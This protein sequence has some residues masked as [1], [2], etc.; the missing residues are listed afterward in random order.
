SKDNNSPGIDAGSAIVSSV[1]SQDI[2]GNIRP[3]GAGFDIGAFEYSSECESSGITSIAV[4]ANHVSCNGGS[5][6]SFSFVGSGGVSPY[7]YSIDGVNFQSSDIFS[8]LS[9]GNYVLTIKDATNCFITVN[10]TVTEPDTFSADFSSTSPSACGSSDGSIEVIPTGGT[11]PYEYNIDDGSYQAGNTFFSLAANSYTIG[12]RDANNCEISIL[13]IIND[14]D[15]FAVTLSTDNVTCNGANDGIISFTASGGTG[16]VEASID[17]TNFQTTAFVNLSFGDYTVIFKDENDC[18]TS[19]D[20]NITEPSALVLTASATDVSCN[21]IED[22]VI[23]VSASGG[24]LGYEY[25]IDGIN[26]SASTTF[27]NLSA[28]DYTVVLRDANGCEVNEQLIIEPMLAATLAKTDITCNGENDGIISFTASGGTGTVEASIDG[29]NFQTTAFVNLASGDYTI[30]LRDENGCE[31]NE[32][33]SI[34]EPPMLAATLAKTD[35]T[36]NGENDGIISFTASGGTGTV[37]ASIDGTNFQ[38]TNFT[39]LTSSNYT[40]TFKDENNC[41]IAVNEAISE[42]DALSLDASFDGSN[43]NLS[44][45]GGIA[46]YNYSADGS[47]FQSESTFT[48]PSG[49]YTFIV[50]DDNACEANTTHTIIITDLET[51][52]GIKQVIAYPNPVTSEIYL[53][54]PK[55]AKEVRIIDQSGRAVFSDNVDE[56]ETRLNISHLE[57]GVYTLLIINNN[58]DV[59]RFKFVKQ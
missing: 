41:I 32:Q 52:L 15:I 39:G 58:G 19:I 29:T 27:N 8:E 5:D 37:E 43:V 44:A 20:T 48:L 42:P 4:S 38:T 2:Q 47:T 12:V 33:L 45:T 35:I 50:K 57:N 36:C 6:G 25:S 59:S 18:T 30:I 21:G 9:A 53:K 14:P 10:W 7:Q 11:A 46:P 13:G 26:F 51:K 34:I 31:V 16:T 49:Q 56:I 55:S 28:N 1:V 40:V 23:T 22:G 17:G 3:Q 54:S 24:T